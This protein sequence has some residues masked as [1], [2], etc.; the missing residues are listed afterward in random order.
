MEDYLGDSCEM[1]VTKVRIDS[2]STHTSTR[3]QIGA[4]N[5]SHASTIHSGRVARF[6]L[7][8]NQFPV[9]ALTA[10]NALRLIDLFD[11]KLL[12]TPLWQ[13]LLRNVWPI[14][15]TIQDSASL[16]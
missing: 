11:T 8:N 4:K 12:L 2:A 13:R 10:I 16:P 3:N 6:C 1:V 9:P 14:V 15:E 5:A 7:R